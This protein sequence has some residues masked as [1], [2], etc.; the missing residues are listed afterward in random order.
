MRS[1]KLHRTFAFRYFGKINL[2]WLA[3]RF[4]LRE[5]RKKHKQLKQI[6]GRKRARIPHVQIFSEC[7]EFQCWKSNLWLKSINVNMEK[8]SDLISIRM[9]FSA[10][11][12]D[13][14]DHIGFVHLFVCFIHW[15]LKMQEIINHWNR[16]YDILLLLPNTI[17]GEKEND[18][19]EPDQT[20]QKKRF[21]S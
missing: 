16:K 21:S 9:D 8:G 2:I 7:E 19:N 13:D 4:H 11:I 15:W 3:F 1:I 14:C 18:E 6:H 20:K 10:I 5:R 17:G 12:R